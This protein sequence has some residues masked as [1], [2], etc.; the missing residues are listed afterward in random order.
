VIDEYTSTNPSGWFRLDSDFTFPSSYYSGGKWIPSDIVAPTAYYSSTCK[1]APSFNGVYI[2]ECNQDYLT[3][4]VPWRDFSSSNPHGLSAANG[5]FYSRFLPGYTCLSSGWSGGICATW[6][7][8][9]RLPWQTYAI[10]W[11]QNVAVGMQRNQSFW[12]NEVYPQG[13]YLRQKLAGLRIWFGL[14][15]P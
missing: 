5:P 1:F 4:S 12:E 13:I 3:P 10:I 14:P 8:A 6:P 2:P 11:G 9:V 15:P 7:N